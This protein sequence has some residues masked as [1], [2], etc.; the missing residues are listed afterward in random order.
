[1]YKYIDLTHT[2]TNDMPVYPGDSEVKL[3]QDKYLIN[4]GYNNSILNIGMHAGTHIDLP[5]HLL[6][7]NLTVDQLSVDTFVGKGCL[8]DV[9]NEPVITMKDEYESKVNVGDIVLLFTG[10]DQY[11]NDA[12]YFSDHPIVDRE[13]AEFFVYKQIK[14]LGMDLPSPDKEPFEIHKTLFQ[15]NIMIIENMRNLELLRAAKWFEVMAFPIK[16]KA[17]AAITRVV[18]KVEL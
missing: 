7:W 6:D 3:Y 17:E 14:M 4:D 15:A 16:V 12:R 11:F 10:F 1:M 8:L 9:R 18:A 13:L 2:I 5:S